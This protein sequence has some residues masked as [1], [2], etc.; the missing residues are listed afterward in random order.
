MTSGSSTTAPQRGR[1]WSAE[2]LAA[3]LSPDL[4]ALEAYRQDLLAQRRKGWA[5]LGISF[6]ISA[7][8]GL[9]A[10][11]IEP[12]AGLVG[13]L[14][15]AISAAVIH[16]K[17]FGSH[18]AV[19]EYEYKRRIIGGMTR[20]LEPSMGYHPERGLPESWFHTSGLYSG[21]VDRYH[22][23]DLF[24][25]RIGS[26]NLWFAEVHAEDKRT[27]TDSKGRRKTYYVTIFKGLLVV[28]DFHK[29]FRS[30]L[31]VTPD[32][33]EKTF[34][35]FGRKLQKLGG[36]VQR[37]ENPEFEKA[38]VVRGPDPVEARY[39]LTPD[40]QERLL[41]LRGRLGADVRFAFRNSHVFMGIPN[42]D[43]WFEPDWN[44]PASSPGQMRLFLSQMATC[45]RIVEDLDLNTRI[46][47]KR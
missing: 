26:T 30:D 42:N 23:E 37:M 12:L 20:V 13:V 18:T 17:Y 19:Y 46:W 11:A 1:P 8:T 32:F 47:T 34:G 44:Q 4:E 3:A 39:I 29:D 24:E 15:F 38:F 2:D 40:M 21:D 28:A 22:S 36:D 10:A 27:R 45:F 43:D 6:L 14:G 7:L 31:L 35:W 16:H 33:A 5:V 25:G 41:S 9:A